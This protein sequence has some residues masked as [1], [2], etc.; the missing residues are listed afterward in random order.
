METFSTL[1][2][3]CA[4]NSP[5]IGEFPHKGQWRGALMFSLAW[6]DNWLNNRDVGN[7]RRHRAHYDVRVMATL[8]RAHEAWCPP[9]SFPTHIFN[10]AKSEGNGFNGWKLFSSRWNPTKSNAFLSYLDFI[11][12]RTEAGIHS[13]GYI[14]TYI[15]Y[16]LVIY[17]RSMSHGCHRRTYQPDIQPDRQVFAN[18]LETGGFPQWPPTARYSWGMT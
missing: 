13:K 11:V 18:H 7:L 8:T 15:F 9:R 10:H 12:F 6:M 4:G 1:L 17:Q 2:A 5:V 14:T 3:I 16:Q